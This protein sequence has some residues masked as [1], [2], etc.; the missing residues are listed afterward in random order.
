MEGHG[1]EFSPMDRSRL[2]APGLD[3]GGNSSPSGGTTGS[4]MTSASEF[5][6]R[7]A[8]PT[9]LTSLAA[10]YNRY[11]LPPALPG[12]YHDCVTKRYPDGCQ[13]PKC[14]KL[15]KI[16]LNVYMNRILLG[17]SY[18]DVIIQGYDNVLSISLAFLQTFSSLTLNIMD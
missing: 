16:H 15:S 3:S 7:T 8:T 14:L 4:G 2:L 10:Q 18:N 17:K 9:P 1:R 5:A 6:T 11:G 13:T 12:E